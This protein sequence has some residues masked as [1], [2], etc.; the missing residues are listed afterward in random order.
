MTK[1]FFRHCA[2]MMMFVILA[3]PVFATAGDMLPY[4]DKV[5]AVITDAIPITDED[6][7]LLTFTAAGQGTH[8]GNFTTL[9]QLRV[10]TL[11]FLFTGTNTLTAAN[12]DRILIDITGSLTPKGYRSEFVIQVDTTFVGGTGRF[13]KATGGFQGEGSLHLEDGFARTTFTGIGNGTI[14]KPGKKISNAQA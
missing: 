6:A 2:A 12:G 5:A 14:S 8:V 4:K 7:V 10:N 13:I 1:T 11:T 9:G 3:C